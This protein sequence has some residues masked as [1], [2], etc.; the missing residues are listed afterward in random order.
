MVSFDLL[1]PFLRG[2]SL[3]FG[4]AF[5]SV[6]FSMPQA[7]MA[8]LYPDGDSGCLDEHPA[9]QYLARHGFVRRLRCPIQPVPVVLR[10]RGLFRLARGFRRPR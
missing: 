2:S 5:G 8:A 6:A 3:A 1:L 4:G 9:V 10:P 7:C